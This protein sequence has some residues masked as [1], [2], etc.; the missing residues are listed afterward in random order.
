MGW[1]NPLHFPL[2]AYKLNG[3]WYFP[4]KEIP[5]NSITKTAQYNLHTNRSSINNMAFSAIL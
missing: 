2:T 4:D 1:R 3:I 5:K